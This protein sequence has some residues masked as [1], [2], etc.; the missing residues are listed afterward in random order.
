MPVS[1]YLTRVFSERE[2]L[3]SEARRMLCS[4]DF[5]TIVGTGLSGAL[6]IPDVA[7]ALDKKWAIVRK[8]N[9]SVHAV[10]NIEGSVGERWLFFDDLIASGRT[11]KFVGERMAAAYPQA[12]YVGVY[13]Y[14]YGVLHVGREY[15]VNQ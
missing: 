3:V 2:D 11:L 1:S 13:E 7:Q 4:I 15:H 14:H 8:D 6:I 12:A 10:Y 9:D 5:D